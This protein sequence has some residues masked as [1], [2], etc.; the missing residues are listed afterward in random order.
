MV[1]PKDPELEG[2]DKSLIQ[3]YSEENNKLKKRDSVIDK[4]HG[5][6]GKN[7]ALYTKSSMFE[8]VDKLLG[9]ENSHYADLEQSNSD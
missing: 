2:D 6:G 8:V 4:A 5:Y 9:I 3:T 7:E 1:P